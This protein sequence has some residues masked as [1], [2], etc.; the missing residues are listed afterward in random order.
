M[1][2]RVEFLTSGCVRNKQ[3]AAVREDRKNGTED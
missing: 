3:V 2:E 1:P